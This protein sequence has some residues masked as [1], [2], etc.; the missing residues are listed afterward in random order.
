MRVMGIAVS[1]VVCLSAAVLMLVVRGA[2]DRSRAFTV[3][4]YGLFGAA[5]V[6]ALAALVVAVRSRAVLKR[7]LVIAGLALPALLAVPLPIWVIV[8]LVPLAD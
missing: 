5:V 4:W 3:V 7:R 1:S 2:A 6:L 8:S